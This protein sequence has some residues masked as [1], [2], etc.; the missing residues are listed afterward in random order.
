MLE[1][2]HMFKHVCS[3]PCASKHVLESAYGHGEAE[4]QVACGAQGATCYDA[5]EMVHGRARAP[6]RQTWCVAV[7]AGRLY[8]DGLSGGH[9]VLFSTKLHFQRGT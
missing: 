1:S 4:A 8:P 3:W 5:T 2:E 9:L 7:D 6:P